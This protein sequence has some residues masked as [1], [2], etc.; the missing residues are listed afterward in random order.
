MNGKGK[1]TTSSTEVFQSD[2]RYCLHCFLSTIPGT[3]TG[4]N[5]VYAGH[6]PFDIIRPHR[7]AIITDTGTEKS[8]RFG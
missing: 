2:R 4:S 6:D 7:D 3:P 8:A 5:V 1:A